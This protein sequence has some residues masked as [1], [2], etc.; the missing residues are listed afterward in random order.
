MFLKKL[1]K[2]I[3]DPKVDLVNI[4]EPDYNLVKDLFL[5]GVQS[6]SYS[7][8]LTKDS[9]NFDLMIKM[10]VTGLSFKDEYSRRVFSLSCI[11]GG[12]S[13]GFMTL[14]FDQKDVEIW[15]FSIL[16]EYRNLGL[17][18]KFLNCLFKFLEREI[19]NAKLFARVNDNSQSMQSL[20][21]Q[22]GFTHKGENNQ[23]YKFFYM[24]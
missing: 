9:N 3:F 18:G 17:G 13:I 23:G 16:E 14:A 12:K 15:H 1:I 6:G 10:M 22:K 5:S 19:P 8:D 21:R 2:K 4:S 20:L 24:N 11:Y 7:S